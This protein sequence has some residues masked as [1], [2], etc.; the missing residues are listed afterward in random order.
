MRH[1]LACAA[2]ISVFGFVQQANAACQLIHDPTE[3]QAVQNDLAGNY[4]LANDINLAGVANF[5]PIGDGGNPFTRQFNGRGHTISNLKID[6]HLES[7]GLFGSTNHATIENL[8]ITSASVTAHDDLAYPE[9]GILVGNADSTVIATTISRVKVSG[10]VVCTGSCNG[11]GLIGEMDNQVTLSRSSSAADV[12]TP[13][14]FGYAG[15]AV[16]F[17]GNGTVTDTYATGT[18]TCGG[19][20]C[21]AG[22]LVGTN[23]G[24]VQFS[25]ATGPVSGG[26]NG[27][28]AGG[29]IG[30]DVSSGP[31]EHSFATG[32]VSVGAGGVAGGLSGYSDFNDVDQCYAIGPVSGGAG[33]SLGGLIGNQPNPVNVTSS[34][35]DTETSGQA[36]SVGGTA[37]TTNQL[38]ASVPTGFDASWAVSHGLSFPY[39]TDGMMDF[40]SPLATLV[41]NNKVFTFLPIS[42][43]DKSLYGGPAVHFSQA[44]LAIV[45]T[46]IARAVGITDNV[47]QL[48]NVKATRYFWDD[49]TQTTT[50]RGP[51][52][53]H[54]TLGTLQSIA[55]AT[56]IGNQVTSLMRAQNLVILRGTYDTGGRTKT[57]WMLGTLYTKNPDNSLAL[58]V[59][60]DPRTGLQVQIDPNTKMVVAPAN[61][62]LTNFTVNGYQPVSID[63]GP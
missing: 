19:D 31:T 34:Y 29:L 28:A 39:L 48:K 59:A 56:P 6:S 36:T 53:M 23:D 42:E 63:A 44:S 38:R 16:G 61:F 17:V 50:F 12:L 41:R 2:A 32:P 8:N 1:T 15:G 49:S 26:A 60:N 11:G 37:K 62:P 18:V 3:L 55:P 5:T 13:V 4:C 58:I 27:G 47:D 35:W 22:G 40:A 30:Y 21:Y 9:V 33:A 51:V 14:N 52:T 10:K 57:H 45:Y 20:A 54:A 43:F 7:V 25:F 24:I 46:M